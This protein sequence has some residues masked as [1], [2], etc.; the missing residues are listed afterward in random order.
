MGYKSSR[1]LA[2]CRAFSSFVSAICFI[3]LFAF[4]ALSIY[5]FYDGL[6]VNREPE[7]MNELRK[8]ISDGAA[9]FSWFEGMVGWLKIDGT[10]IDYPVMQGGDNKWYLSH[11][12]LGREAMSGS[13]FL[14]YRNNSDFRDDLSVI[15][16]HRMN[17]DLMFSD[18]AKFADADYFAEHQDGSLKTP[19]GEYVLRVV[20]HSILS[21]EEKVY[22]EMNVESLGLKPGK[23]LLLSTCNRSGRTK[24]D[25]LIVEMRRV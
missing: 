4:T 13:A 21:A 18:V 22:D 2:L 6:A 3:I 12:Y 10:H 17:G 16:G 9:A 24:R 5:A 23:F 15:Y 19:N 8:E 20:A 7:E 25:V 14:D 11:D 1:Y